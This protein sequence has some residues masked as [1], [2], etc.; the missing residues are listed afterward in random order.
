MGQW[1]GQWDCGGDGGGGYSGEGVCED[2]GGT[3]GHWYS[4][5]SGG[6]RGD[7]ETEVETLG[8]LSGTVVGTAGTGG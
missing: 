2:G 6:D 1:W 5:D 3:T 7:S 8:Q 4:V